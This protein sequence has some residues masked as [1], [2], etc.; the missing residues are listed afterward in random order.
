MTA[1]GGRD[2]RRRASLVLLCATLWSGCDSVPPAL[3]VGDAGYTEEELGALT[4]AQRHRLGLLTALGLAVADARL[5]DV[6]RPL[7]REARDSL[8]VERYVLEQAARLGGLDQDDLRAAYRAD[9]EHRLT[10]RHLVIL[11]ERWRDREERARAEERAREALGRVSAGAD[12]ATVAAEVS[13]EPGAS[14][15]GG[16]LAPGRRGAW[17]PEF[18]TA[19]SAL[20]EGEVSGVV[21]TRYGYHVLQLVRRDT[22]PFDSVRYDVMPGILEVASALPAARREVALQP[23]SVTLE[24]ARGLGIGVSPAES[25][26]LRSQWTDRVVSL[27][28]LFGFQAGSSTDDVKRA[29]LL[30]LGDQR[31]SVRIA[32]SE[33]PEL[34]PALEQVFPIR[35]RERSVP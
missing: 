11:A 24:R 2:A 32:L 21:E 9:P 25:E 18:W 10:V 6:T 12:L 31:Q 23:R 19:A 3:Q 17:V 30:A 22:V 4:E 35:A 34:A 7:I 8:I 28:A 26:A 1:I 16:L 27:A 5:D 14:G 29:A 20:A 33:L 15:S 13:E